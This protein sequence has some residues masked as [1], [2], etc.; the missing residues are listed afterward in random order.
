MRK[1]QIPIDM[2]SIGPFDHIDP[3][4]WGGGT[5]RL[6][7]IVWSEGKIRH[8]EATPEPSLDMVDP[9]RRP[10]ERLLRRLGCSSLWP[11]FVSSR[12]R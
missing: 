4:F 1:V 7:G 6:S 5:P 3:H 8:V 2:D 12:A 11:I 9:V 10:F